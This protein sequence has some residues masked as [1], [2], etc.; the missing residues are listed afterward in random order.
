M[1]PGFWLAIS[2]I[3]I[4]HA[5][6]MIAFQQDSFLIRH[7]GAQV[8]LNPLSTGPFYMAFLFLLPWL[9]VFGVAVATLKLLNLVE[10]RHGVI[11]LMASVVAWGVPLVLNLTPLSGAYMDALDNCIKNSRVLAQR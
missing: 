1:G 6:S 9:A 5:I 2:G 4:W 10:L 8:Y 7:C 3:E 11:A